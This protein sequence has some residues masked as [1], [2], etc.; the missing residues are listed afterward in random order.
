M[1]GC[2]GEG[3]GDKDGHADDDDALVP[4]RLSVGGF[5]IGGVYGVLIHG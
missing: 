2:E 3:Q 5:W 1:Q 4:S